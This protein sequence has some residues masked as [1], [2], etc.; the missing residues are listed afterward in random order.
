MRSG[1]SAV[2]RYTRAPMLMNPRRVLAFGLVAAILGT[3]HCRP[4]EGVQK[5]PV[6]RE[7]EEALLQYLRIDTSNPPGN[8]SNGARFLQQ[9]LSKEG[10]ESQLLGS[11]PARQSLYARLRSG[12]PEKALILMHHIDVVPAVASEWTKPPFAGLRTGGYLWGRGALDIK[13]LGIAE[14]M[15]FVELKRRNLPLDRDVIFLAVADEE[16]GGAHGCGALLAEHPE[17]F[18]DVGFVLNEGGYAET[19]VDKVTFWGIETEQKIPLWIR[20]RAKG[21]AGHGAAPPD[22]GGATGKLVAALAKVEAIERP[23]R[24]TPGVAAYFHRAGAARH[25]GRGEFLRAIADPLDPAKIEKLLP[26]GYRSL[27]RDTMAITRLAAGNAVNAI[28]ATATA[29]LDLRLLPDGNPAAEIAKIREAVG[30][31]CEVEVILEGE[32]VGAS[33]DDTPLF[34]TLARVMQQSEPGSVVVPAVGG[35]TSDSRFF[36]ARGITAYGIAPFKVN[37]YDADGVHASDERI[38]ATFFAE[39]VRL[40]RRIVIDFCARKAAA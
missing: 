38:R 35:G 39:G 9:L 4:A 13:S 5:D 24:L 26:S 23:Y 40:M 8:E 18:R 15:A 30:E 27:L 10:I 31:L 19:V 11:D 34:R 7:A 1:R 37:Y 12:R 6:E 14:L 33:S 17:L 36:R 32:R 20:L 2:S 22:D 25:D 3:M 16:M 29:D 28:P 21:V